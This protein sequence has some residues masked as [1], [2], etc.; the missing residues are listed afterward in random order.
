M[1]LGSLGLILLLLCPPAVWAQPLPQSSPLSTPR[2]KEYG[3]PGYPQITVYVWG[4]ADTGVWQVEKGTDLLEFASVIS[5]VRLEA[6]DPSRRIV[7]LLQIY[8]DG[9]TDGEPFFESKI[10]DLFTQRKGYPEMQD[11]DILVLQRETKGRFTWRDAAQIFTTVGT[12]LNTY[13]ILDRI[14]ND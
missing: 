3:R 4:S 11:G 14:R 7:N 8:R 2:V 5:Q 6:G 1:L 9:S 10:G 12:I 13:L